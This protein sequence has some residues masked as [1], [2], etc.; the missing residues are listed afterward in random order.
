MKDFDTKPFLVRFKFYPKGLILRWVKTWFYFFLLVNIFII[1]CLFLFVFLQSSN[2]FF[3]AF[4]FEKCILEKLWKVVSC[5]KKEVLVRALVRR[6]SV[7]LF[8][9]KQL[10][11]APSFFR[12]FCQRLIIMHPFLL[13]QDFLNKIFIKKLK[14]WTWFDKF[15]NNMKKWPQF[16]IKNLNEQPR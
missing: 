4:L 1:I 8:F 12:I 16:C 6:Q 5:G 9:S 15:W 11:R 2:Y 10:S 13:L 3:F 7:L 14:N